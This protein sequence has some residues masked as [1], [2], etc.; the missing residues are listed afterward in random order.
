MFRTLF[1][2]AIAVTTCALV[3]CSSDQ[4]TGPS[5]DKK[6]ALDEVYGLCQ[7]RAEQGKP[8][9]QKADDL[10]NYENA[11]PLGFAVVRS[12]EVVVNWGTAPAAGSESVLAY[13]K[14]VPTAGGW[15]VLQNGVVKRMTADEFKAAPK[16][17]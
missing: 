6:A 4:P 2:A 10:R 8:P 16:A 1:V 12:G 7:L 13:Q 3:G 14:D 11:Y 15:A 9:A 5:D 17:K